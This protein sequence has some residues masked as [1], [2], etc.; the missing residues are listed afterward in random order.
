[1]IAVRP[2]NTVFLLLSFEGPDPYS[3]AGGLGVRMSGLAQAL[4]DRGFDT[5]LVFYGDPFLP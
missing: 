3:L 4:A 1:M 2:E 5:H